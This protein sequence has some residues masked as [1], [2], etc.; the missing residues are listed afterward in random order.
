MKEKKC[1]QNSGILFFTAVGRGRMWTFV[2]LLSW[3]FYKDN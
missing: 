3:I 1:E 2:P